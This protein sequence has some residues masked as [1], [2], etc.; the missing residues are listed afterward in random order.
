LGATNRALQQR[1]QE[2]T[3]MTIEALGTVLILVG[4]LFALVLGLPLIVGVI[5]LD[6]SHKRLLEYATQLRSRSSRVFVARKQPLS[7]SNVTAEATMRGPL[8]EAGHELF[9]LPARPAAG[10]RGR[11]PLV[12]QSLSYG[13]AQVRSLEDRRTRHDT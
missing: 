8:P 7:A 2:G 9:G 10:P 13:E 6:A 5:R 12:V 3:T 11:S 1:Q 4:G